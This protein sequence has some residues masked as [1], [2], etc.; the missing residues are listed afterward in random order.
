MVFVHI[1]Q[2]PFHPSMVLVTISSSL[3][4]MFAAMQSS[5]LSLHW[6]SRSISCCYGKGFDKYLGLFFPI[7]DAASSCLI[8]CARYCRWAGSRE[9]QNSTV[10]SRCRECHKRGGGTHQ[11]NHRNPRRCARA[12]T[13]APG[14]AMAGHPASEITPMLMPSCKG[15][16]KPGMLLLSV[17]LFNS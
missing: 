17:N 16:R 3:H 9:R 14:S 12:T 11:R 7:D 5:V 1:G 15:C 2:V 10:E 8:F 6:V 4:E 13:S